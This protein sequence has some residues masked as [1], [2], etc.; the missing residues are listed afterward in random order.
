MKYQQ[1]T[2]VRTSYDLLS[3]KIPYLGTSN[4][5]LPISTLKY[6]QKEAF[7]KVYL[8]HIGLSSKIPTIYI[9]MECLWLAERKNII[10]RHLCSLVAH[11]VVPKNLLK[12]R[13]LSAANTLKVPEMASKCRETA[14]NCQ[15]W[16][17]GTYRT[18]LKLWLCCKVILL[19]MDACDC[20][21]PIKRGL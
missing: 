16:C 14:S 6:A 17:H 13:L 20:S 19:C 1:Y 21:E 15:K 8:T 18:Q 12:K 11:Y 7:L 4:H 5:L 9:C 10:L 3:A 2:Y